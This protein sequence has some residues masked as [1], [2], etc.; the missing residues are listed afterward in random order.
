MSFMGGQQMRPEKRSHRLLGITRSKAKMYEYDVPI[1]HHIDIGTQ[2]PA[3]LFQLTIGLLGEFAARINSDGDEEACRLELK[4][5]CLFS[6][7]FFDSYLQSK[8]RED[9]EPYLLLLGSAAYYLCDLPGSAGVLAGYLY[10]DDAGH[11][12]GGGLEGLLQWLL[13]GD[14]SNGVEETETPYKEHIIQVPERM[15]QFFKE[16]ERE[17]LLECLTSFRR[18]VYGVGSARQLLFVDVIC[19][20][21]KKRIETSAWICFPKYSGISGNMWKDSLSKTNFIKEL[22]PA[23]QLLGKQGVFRGK[24]AVVQ[25]PTSAGKTKAVEIVIRSAFLS[26]RTSLAVIVAP[27]RAL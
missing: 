17:G 3:R 27:F 8:L 5:H 13:K 10:G 4:K 12:Y 14:F 6:A 16:G 9:I 22:W 20:I 2:D 19:A 24:S 1:D 7:Q 15:V 11:L 25:M 21:A 23:Q 26:E 18:R